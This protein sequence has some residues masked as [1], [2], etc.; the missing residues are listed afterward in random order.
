MA[1]KVIFILCQLLVWLGF[2]LAVYFATGGEIK[3]AKMS[4]LVELISYVGAIALHDKSEDYSDV[5]VGFYPAIMSFL[6]LF[7]F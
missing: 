6:M 5:M 4:V 3:L 7:Y 2:F 1:K